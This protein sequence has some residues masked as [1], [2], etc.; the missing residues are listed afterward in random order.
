M[1]MVGPV[2]Y[3][4]YLEVVVIICV[5]LCHRVQLY[6]NASAEDYRISRL[7]RPCAMLLRQTFGLAIQGR[8]GRG[9]SMRSGRAGDQLHAQSQYQPLI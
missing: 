6:G 7:S 3:L 2:S 5:Y 1:L 4:W 9:A 8:S